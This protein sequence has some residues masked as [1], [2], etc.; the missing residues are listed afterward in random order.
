VARNAGGVAAARRPLR[1]CVDFAKCDISF[2]DQGDGGKMKSGHVSTSPP[3]PNMI[4][5][6]PSVHDEVSNPAM[7]AIIP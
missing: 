6:F 4:A 3:V 1:Q 2:F 7:I 5:V